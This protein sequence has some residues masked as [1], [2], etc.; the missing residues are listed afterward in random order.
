MG[1]ASY[2]YDD[3]DD[4]GGGKD[5]LMLFAEVNRVRTHLVAENAEKKIDALL[6]NYAHKL[7]EVPHKRLSLGYVE[8]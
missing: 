7:G 2:C 5:L 1:A 4:G 6:L 3:D 8:F